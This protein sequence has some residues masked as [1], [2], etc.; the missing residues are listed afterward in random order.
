MSASGVPPQA[1]G[2]TT[3]NTAEHVDA[4]LAHWILR[5]M[6]VF[7]AFI[8]R[9]IGWT[10]GGRRVA[11]VKPRHPWRTPIGVRVGQTRGRIIDGGA[12]TVAE[13]AEQIAG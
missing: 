4:A 9:G 10:G 2:R 1:T 11:R 8:L 7:I 6:V 13:R 12:R 3:A 5:W